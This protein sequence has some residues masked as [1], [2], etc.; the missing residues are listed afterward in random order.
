MGNAKLRKAVLAKAAPHARQDGSRDYDRATI[1]HLAAQRTDSTGSDAFAGF[2]NSAA[3]PSADRK[4]A[5]KHEDAALP[6]PISDA[7]NRKWGL[8]AHAKPKT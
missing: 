3:D 7:Y 4:D 6:S 5:A 1:D 8:G 2:F